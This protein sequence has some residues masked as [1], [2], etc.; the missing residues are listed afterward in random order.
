M[1][2]C[3][4][5]SSFRRYE[6]DYAG[7][8]VYAQ[9]C[10]LAR[11][12]D[13]YVIYP[14]DRDNPDKG[15]DPFHHLPFE[16]PYRTY[17]M[18]Q[19]HGL[20]ILNSFKLF[21]LMRKEIL[22]AKKKYNIDL[23]YAFWTIP[24]ALI[25]S[26]VCGDTPYIVNVAGADDKVFGR[27]G[28][29]RP[30][31]KRALSKASRV[32][33]LSQ[34]L[35]ADAISMNIKKENIYVI[36]SGINIDLYKPRNKVEIR[37]E[38]GLP[39]KF[40]I[41]YVGSLF[42]LKRIEWLIRISAELGHT[43]KFH[44]LI[45]GDGP[46]KEKL[47]ALA[48]ELKADNIEFLGHVPYHRVP[49][50]ISSS[51]ALVLFSETEGLPSVVQEA[52]ACGIPV[53][54]TDVGGVKDIVHQGMSGFVVKTQE[55]AKDCL[56]Y[57]IES[58]HQVGHMGLIARKYAESRLSHEQV[59]KHV[60]MVCRAAL[61]SSKINKHKTITDQEK[62]K[63]AARKHNI[64]LISTFPSNLISYLVEVQAPY[65][66]KIHVIAPELHRDD[67]VLHSL[68]YDL[69]G[70]VFSQTLKQI[71]AQLR[72]SFE[73]ARLGD[74]VDFWNFFG[75]D[76]FIL[77]ILTA[78]L[79]G[80]PVLLSLLGNLEYE[81]TVKKNALNPLQLAIK[82]INCMLA[83]RIIVYSQSLVE[84][85]RLNQY[86]SKLLVA[87]SQFVDL[88][89]FNIKKP[90]A[91]RNKL[92]GYVGR[93]STEKGIWNLIKSMPLVLKQDADVRLM[94]IGNGPLHSTIQEFLE[95]DGLKE[96]VY[97]AGKVPFEQVPDWMNQLRLLVMPSFSEG[98]PATL[99]E[100]MACGTPVLATPVGAVDDV[101]TSGKTGFLLENNSQEA[102]AQGIMDALKNPQGE[103][104][105]CA[106]RKLI[107]TEFS[108]PAA[109]RN[110]EKVILE[111]S[112]LSDR[113]NK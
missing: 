105:A 93:L 84:K 33:S 109:R 113:Q 88:K 97:L 38:L 106:A 99:L 75:G 42:K 73:I 71:G 66:D 16:Y 1:K 68:K 50:Y 29:A 107:E 60:D 63:S 11:Q 85:W 87:Q 102:I 37:E 111:G 89:K 52:L 76:V 44:S 23:F 72:M 86:D 48:A 56:T 110:Y 51:N 18:A 96:K 8:H 74:A 25:C 53:V 90:L 98:L 32:I 9:A 10:G 81:T 40:L 21:S 41:V 3:I 22:N 104:I 6:G 49:Y 27:G 57:L 59:F 45:I 7:Q 70:N 28:I 112:I 47:Q 14:T 54:A 82:K 78:K 101:I 83:N 92:I 36:P 94:I 80:K 35:K 2:I 43:H 24:N 67:V 69:S 91:T 30:L 20:D 62:Q 65:A 19:V 58:P 95:K 26:M 4:V 103:S 77:P 61:V 100:A 13:V 39:D 79:M 64:G 17:P 5:T 34:D 31:V 55:E 15:R 12:H 108:L 46:E